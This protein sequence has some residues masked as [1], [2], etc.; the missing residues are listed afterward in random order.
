MLKKN[1]EKIIITNLPAFYKVNLFN[2][3]NERLEI[4]VIFTGQNGDIR[5]ESFYTDTFLFDYIELQ[6]YGT[7]K[8]ILKI[9]TI[10][11]RI[12][13]RELIIGGWDS[14]FYWICVFLN[15][16]RK[17]SLI[18]ESSHFESRI[19][20]LRGF[21]KRIF[22]KRVSK[23]YASGYSQK[24]L[25][26]DL[27]FHS[28]I[29]KTKGVGIFNII[30]QAPFSMATE[31]KNFLYVGRFSP[32]KNLVN[33]IKVFNSLPDYN[34]NFIGYGPQY[35]ELKAIGKC[36]IYFHGSI[37]NEDLP[38]YYKNND[39]LILP[40]IIEPWGLVVEEALN[41][42]LPVIV[43]NRVG[44][45]EEIIVENFNGLIFKYDDLN[46][47]SDNVIKITDVRLYNEMRLNIS[48]MD[49]KQV[50]SEQVNLYI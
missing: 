41:N 36:N 9:V 4:L 16:K 32:E 17:N 27:G 44:C 13:F 10:I 30:E 7:I 23:V 22:L 48:K 18:V 6:Q 47:L 29:V 45:T 12:G 28:K 37:R 50:A 31:V 11:N 49:F 43:S 1:Y 21:F 19:S 20:G 2:R 3:I 34:L 33:L 26:N 42:G 15:P 25:V 46:D 5:N 40:S 38:Y 24:K 35:E 39:V 14:I 8:R